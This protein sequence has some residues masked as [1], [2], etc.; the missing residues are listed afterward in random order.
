MLQ[1]TLETE[2]KEFE[3]D[4]RKKLDKISGNR[5]VIDVTKADREFIGMY[6]IAIK[7]SIEYGDNS[8]RNVYRNALSRFN[9]MVNFRID[10]V[11]NIRKIGNKIRVN[12]GEIH[13]LTTDEIA[14]KKELKQ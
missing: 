4:L 10:Y 7:K 6:E 5:N 3:E 12:N 2:L 11:S 14:K 1:K 8:F 13:E 9:K